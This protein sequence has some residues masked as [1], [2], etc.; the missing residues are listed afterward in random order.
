MHTNLDTAGEL[1]VCAVPGPITADGDA[2]VTLTVTAPASAGAITNYAATNPTGTGNPGTPPDAGCTSSATTSC[3][4]VPTT[5]NAPQLTLAKTHVGNFTVGV[6]GSYVLTPSNTGSSP[7]T[8]TVTIVDTLPAGLTYLSA[9]GTGWT[10]AA[11]AQVVTCTSTTA[12]AAGTA[13]N[14]ITLTVGVAA[15][16]SPAV[17]NSARASGGGDATCPASGA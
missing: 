8:G 1:L 10:C 6:N 11:A 2:V 17:T 4:S 12:I 15:A 3:S 14:A 9:T 7:T 13:G 16:A 5:V